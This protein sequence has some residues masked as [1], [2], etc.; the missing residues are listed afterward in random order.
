M[1]AATTAGARSGL[2]R[3]CMEQG[4]CYRKE[5]EPIDFSEP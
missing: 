1:S 3:R 4:G 2:A 5:S